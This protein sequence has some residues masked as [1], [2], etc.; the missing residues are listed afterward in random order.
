MNINL[1]NDFDVN[2]YKFFNDDLKNFNNEQ[3][4]NHYL[5]FGIHENRI[6]KYDLPEDFDVDFY[7]NYYDDL[8]DLNKNELIYHYIK[9][10]KHEGRIY[11][12]INN[13][14]NFNFN[15]DNSILP[16]DFDPYI[17]KSLYSDIQHMNKDEL[18]QH[19]LN[20]GINEYRKYKINNDISYNI[21]NNKELYNYEINIDKLYNTNI[22]ISLSTIPNRFLN[23]EFEDVIKSLLNQILKPKNIVINLCKD[24]IRNFKYNKNDFDNKIKYFENNYNNIII[25]ITKD[26]GPITKILG[27]YNIINNFNKDDIVIV[28]DD[29][30]IMNNYMTYYYGLIYQLYNS[31]CVFINELDIIE[32]NSNR[33]LNIF[34]NIFY[35]N[36]QNFGYGWLSYSIKAKY[37]DLLYNFYNDIV[38]IDNEIIYHDDLIITLF[39]KIN[40]LYACGINL[41]MNKLNYLNLD[42]V[43]ALK[44][45]N[46]SFNKRYNLEIKFLSMYNIKYEIINNRIYITNLNNNILLYNIDKNINKRYLLFNTDNISYNPEENNYHDKHIDIKYFNENIFMLTITYFNNNN[47]SDKIYLKGL[48]NNTVFNLCLDIDLKNIFSKKITYFIKIDIKL[49]IINHINYNFKII[50]TNNDYSLS[51]NKFYSINTILSYIPDIEYIIFDNNDRINYLKYN[52]IYSYIY[53]KLNVGA[54][55]ADFFRAIYMYNNGGIY[56]DCKN[57]LFTHI[58]YL[59]NKYECYVKDYEKG[60]CNGFFYCSYKNDIKLKNYINEMIY[61][62]HNSLYLTSS[63]EITGPLLFE[64]HINNNIFLKNNFKDDWKNSYFYD[65]SNNN[66][67]IKISYYGY[68]QENNYLNTS[69]YSILYN[70]KNIYNNINI[71]YNKINGIDYILWINLERSLDRKN[72][73][74]NLLNNINITNKRM[75]PNEAESDHNAQQFDDRAADAGT[76]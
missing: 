49:N 34:Y 4:I 71:N 9:Y 23:E 17:Y 39:Y 20:Y 41:F 6:Y 2:A 30:W 33:K 35:D 50:Q 3:L 32:W 74:E 55:K 65:L 52:N 14:F 73:M 21:I 44:N 57:I 18:I 47:D 69:H 7:R 43:N 27:L 45:E 10:G 19:Y 60:I 36:Y 46:D 75:N 66:I 62:I 40:N 38:N 59:L 67:I 72:N 11:N 22:I 29:D 5:K 61:N 15:E 68:Y 63:L 64:K 51:I 24:Y 76:L 16:Y 54:Y 8:K 12:N 25:N 42:I 53:E 56:F 58:N 31:D 37:I 13:I 26:Y 48:N 28:L 1:P 70:N